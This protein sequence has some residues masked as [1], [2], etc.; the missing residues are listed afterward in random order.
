MV[1]NKFIY[2]LIMTICWV[3]FIA[4]ADAQR[5]YE[6]IY[7]N[8]PNWSV[9][10]SY[11]ELLDFQ[12][13]SPYFANVYI[14]LGMICEQKLINTD[15][16]REIEDTKYW[17]KNAE[18]FW[19]NFKVFYKDG[20]ARHSDYYEN[21]RIPQQGRHL[22]DEEVMAFV[23]KHATFCKN[24]SDTAMIL[25][26][27]LE[28]SKKAYNTCL[29]MYR[30]ICDV[31]PNLNELLLRSNK[32]LVDKL[33]AIEASYETCITSFKEYKDI[34][35]VHSLL[36][37]RQILDTKEIQTFRLDGLTNSD[38]LQNRFFV[39]DFKSWVDNFKSTLESD[40]LP[41]RKEI[42]TINA[43]Y[44]NG[45]E[46]WKKGKA[47][48]VNANP[49]YDDLFLFR[50]GRYDSN[51]LVRELFSY[52]DSR[53]QLM[54]MAQDSLA[55]PLDSIPVTRNRHLRHLY[56]SSQQYVSSSQTL[57]SLSD[58]ISEEQNADGQNRFYDFFK[59]NKEYTSSSFISHEG[60]TLR[61]IFQGMLVN[62]VKYLDNVKDVA[63]KE[64]TY[65]VASGKLPAIPMW[66][67]PSDAETTNIQGQ[68]I[69]RCLDYNT[70]GTPA[71]V[72][73]D[74]ILAGKQQPFVAAISD[75]MTTLWTSQINKAKSVL[76]VKA[77][78]AGCVVQIEADKGNY[79]VYLNDK[80][81][82]TMRVETPRYTMKQ[83]I[84]N[85]ITGTS[86]LAFDADTAACITLLDSLHNVIRTIDLPK[87]EH[88]E[89]IQEVTNG[90]FVVASNNGT[91]TTLLVNAD[92]VIAKGTEEDEKRINSS[93]VDI[94][95]SSAH[96]FCII[97][98]EESGTLHYEIIND[99]LKTLLY[100]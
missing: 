40:I 70:L 13:K 23:E 76:A 46:E 75:Q 32:E 100:L 90:H 1:K 89:S 24:Y 84:N 64:Y 36:N 29:A 95:R 69:T 12:Q 20:D 37:Y 82:E 8:L 61:E 43:R 67:I 68:Y 26:E 38:F 22:T 42:E 78:E 10:Q 49:A 17:A 71:Y 4:H 72:A 15:P 83:M 11:S 33:S 77:Y 58:Y 47:C 66:A 7:M 94:F 85:A 59:K 18:I 16:L 31:Y 9:D 97:S 50:L 2:L 56:R 14:Q 34:L 54:S 79:L 88:I 73:G 96:D 51:S 63:P 3:G 81:K 91:L 21:L 65:S 93:F 19:G 98:K 27:N 48:V 25:Y 41:L 55:L 30:E 86:T 35:K 99:D 52:L 92:G 5:K 53:R 6:D 87:I 60:Q 28:K 80:G 62:Y 45:L 44:V 57:A 39:W 74:R